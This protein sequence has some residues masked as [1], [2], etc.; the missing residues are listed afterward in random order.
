[1]RFSSV[2]IF[3]LLCHL[4]SLAQKKNNVIINKDPLI[5]SLIARRIAL[6]TEKPTTANPNTGV[7]VTMMGFRVQIFYGSNRKQA[8]EEQD[9]FRNSYPE[10]G[11]YITYKEPNYHLKVGDFRTRLEAQKFL[12]ELRGTYP[13]LFVFKEKINPPVLENEK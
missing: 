3:L 9:K 12:E 4:V 2:C 5:D 13:T 1:M 7:A 8:F 11:T 6:Y 10:M